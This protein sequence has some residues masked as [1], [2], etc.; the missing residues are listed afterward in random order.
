MYIRKANSVD[1]P[2]VCR[3]VQQMTPGVQHNYQA[4]IQKFETHIQNNPDYFLWVATV[5]NL[6]E[7]RGYAVV[8]TAMMHFQ[9]K[10]SYNCGTAAHLED[11]VVDNDWRGTGIG[12]ELVRL[13]IETARANNAYKL[14][15]TCFPKTVEYYLQFGFVKHDIGMRLSLKDEFPSK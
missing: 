7:E 2:E 11:V 10:L 5:D 3:I 8:G 13:A 14:M 9:H 1:I 6:D 15:L 4:A 12:R